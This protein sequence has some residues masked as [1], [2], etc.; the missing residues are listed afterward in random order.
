MIYRLPRATPTGTA[1]LTLSPL[2]FLAALARLA[3]Q[4]PPPLP[5]RPGA[6][7]PLCVRPSPRGRARRHR[8]PSHSRS[9]PK[10]PR[11]RS[12]RARSDSA[13]PPPPGPPKH[14]AL[15]P[16]GVNRLPSARWAR[17]L[18]RVH[19]VFPLLCSSCGG[20]L[21]IIAFLAPP[22]PVHAILD[23]LGL[24]SR[25]SPLSPARAPP[26]LAFDF[27]PRAPEFLHD[28]TPAFDAADPEP[29]PAFEFDQT[30]TG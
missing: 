5:R 6:P 14:Q 26:K 23:H 3:A 13:P 18:A 2:E 11:R 4:P 7:R 24:P 12:R 8:W 21:R 30:R 22:E 29:I 25:P 20:Q 9:D 15:H 1:V 17:L 19:E 16:K 27:D 28:Q 10:R